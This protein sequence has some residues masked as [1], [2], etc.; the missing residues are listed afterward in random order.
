MKRSFVILAALLLCS[1]SAEGGVGTTTTRYFVPKVT[2]AT[3]AETTTTAPTSFAEQ[4][5][6]ADD[7]GDYEI[8]EMTGVSF[9]IPNSWKKVYT[10]KDSPSYMKFQA[11][12]FSFSAQF[13]E[14]F[15]VD[16]LQS[17]SDIISE[18]Q[19]HF[20]KDIIT[21]LWF[22]E[23][24][25]KAFYF[26][27]YKINS[28]SDIT[29]K[30]ACQSDK[31][32]LYFNVFEFSDRDYAEKQLA[33]FTRSIKGNVDF[34]M[35]AKSKKTTT[36]AATTKKPETITTE[37]TTTKTTT[38]KPETTVPEQTTTAEIGNYMAYKAAKK[39]LSIMPFSRSGLIKQLEYEGYSHADAQQAVDDCDVTWSEQAAKKAKEYLEIMPFSR[40]GLIKQLQ[41]EGYSEDEAIYG[42]DTTGADWNQQAA[43]KAQE[44]IDLMSFSRDSLVKQLEYEGYTSEQAAY[45]ASAVGY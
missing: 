14:N 29:I 18:L 41:Y 30:Y 26:E 4:T 2:D 15:Y 27:M 44:Y 13:Y 45:G 24:K 33:D 8:Y 39:Y 17:E 43:K 22:A 28:P 3:T 16:T 20:K 1:C 38:T 11:E 6:A 25:A 37:A 31:G 23:N 19:P 5:V 21:D 32:L 12:G 34:I 10:D 42:T 36:I 9:H 40:S 7:P 35:P